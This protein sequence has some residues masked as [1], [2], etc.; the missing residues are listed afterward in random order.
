MQYNT[1]G[2]KPRYR[3]S[4]PAELVHSLQGTGRPGRAPRALA[5][6][7]APHG[8]ACCR[9]RRYDDFSRP[10]VHS[11]W[12]PG[13]SRAACDLNR[14]TDVAT[15]GGSI[16]SIQIPPSPHQHF[17]ASPTLRILRCGTRTM[18]ARAR[19]SGGEFL[20]AASE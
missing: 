9:R 15:P 10:H 18:S 20:K 7:Q 19:G 4:E 3:G 17:A 11:M 1:R 12:R 6:V 13:P 16:Q 8:R 5:G 14:R 2:A